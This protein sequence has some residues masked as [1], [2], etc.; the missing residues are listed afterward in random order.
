[1]PRRTLPT[2]H[3]PRPLVAHLAC[4]A[5]T[6]LFSVPALAQPTGQGSFRGDQ[7]PEQRANPDAPPPRT[8]ARPVGPDPV[9]FDTDALA[10]PAIKIAADQAPADNR[11]VLVIWG[12]DDATAQNRMLASTLAM[13]NVARVLDAEYLVVRAEVGDGDAG[14]A[15]RALTESLK[16]ELSQ[17]PPQAPRSSR[18]GRPRPPQ[19]GDG[20]HPILSVHEPD[21][22]LVATQ[23]LSVLFVR[24]Q[25]VP[26]YEAALVLD[27]LIDQRP[28]R[29]QAP[30][31]L[32]SALEQAAAS[33]KNVF[34]WFAQPRCPDCDDMRAFL[35]ETNIRGLLDNTFV[36]LRID[37]ERTEEGVE[38]FERF[39]GKNPDGLPW[40]VLLNANAEPLAASQ[41]S[42]K[43]NIGMPRS[44]DQIAR[45]KSALLRSGTGLTELGLA[46][47]E[48]SLVKRRTAHEARLAEAE[49][50]RLQAQEEA[51]TQ[52]PANDEQDTQ[53]RK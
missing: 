26:Q 6:L 50:A 16:I 38:L 42:G 13:F 45:F 33:K 15:N 29:P 44:D 48:D 39:A 5:L 25:G 19:P 7:N 47:I 46:L 14:A 3:H 12:R 2:L 32:E 23:P 36:L 21:G 24:R 22:S 43:P 17:E 9:R 20:F 30:A 49:A 4:A 40:F 28:P 35:D 8:P 53:N 41:E 11:R 10:E 51:Q 52:Q 37:I 1:M 34:L 18:T 31:L 27:W